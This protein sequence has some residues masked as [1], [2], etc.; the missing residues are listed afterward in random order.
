MAS[1][2]LTFE[3]N[4]QSVTTTW[5]DGVTEI[6]P[7]SDLITEYKWYYDQA[8]RKFRDSLEAVRTL[9]GIARKDSVT[10]TQEKNNAVD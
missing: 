6:D 9:S 7:N 10:G 3:F 5:D 1:V 4:G 2:Y 8:F